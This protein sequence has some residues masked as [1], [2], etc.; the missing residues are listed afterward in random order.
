MQEMQ[1]QF[2]QKVEGLYGLLESLIESHHATAVAIRESIESGDGSGYRAT[3]R[4]DPIRHITAAN[5]ALQEARRQL[6]ASS[7][8]ILRVSRV[9]C[10]EKCQN[11]S[12]ATSR[13]AR[14]IEAATRD[15][16]GGR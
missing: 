15:V 8:S 3:P 2:Y 1:K 4:G 6:L 13:D 11:P 7:R 10:L 14:C 9:K 5:E 12:L 16:E